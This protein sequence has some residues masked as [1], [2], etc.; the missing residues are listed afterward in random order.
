MRVIIA[1]AGEVGG[2]AAEVLSDAGHNVTVVDLDAVRL[3]SLNDTLDVRTLVGHCAHF[4]VLQEAGADRCDLMLAAT[5]IDEINMLAASMAKA[6]GTKKTIVRVHHTANFSLRG[7]SY[8][9]QLGID[10]LICPEYL[11][12]LAIA[13]AVR[14]PGSIALEEFARGQLMMQRVDVQRAAPA[15]GRTL[16]ELVMPVGVR[17][18]WRRWSVT[19]VR[20]SRTPGRR[21][22]RATS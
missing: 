15:V 22:T 4:D 9:S 14:N 11:C 10:E 17:V 18:A 20:R 13:R 12:S 6:S 1:G 8:A 5:Q 21:S 7:T 3:Q 2:H 16:A 19:A